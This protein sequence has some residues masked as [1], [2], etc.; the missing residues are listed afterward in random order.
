MEG[1]RK[2]VRLAAQT[3]IKFLEDEQD[4]A[5]SWDGDEPPAQ[6]P[7][8]RVHLHLPHAPA[9]SSL[10]KP[11]RRSVDAAEYD[12]PFIG[13]LPLEPGAALRMHLNLN[14]DVIPQ[15]PAATS[16]VSSR[17]VAASS[18]REAAMAQMTARSR[19]QRDAYFSNVDDAVAHMNA[20]L[21][22]AWRREEKR[23]KREKA[24]VAAERRRLS[25]SSG[26][27]GGAAGAG[28]GSSGGAGSDGDESS[29]G[30]GSESSGSWS[31]S[32]SSSASAPSS[33]SGRGTPE[34]DRLARSV[35]QASALL[36]EVH[37][38]KTDPCWL[39][40]PEHSCSE[41]T[42]DTEWGSAST[43]TSV[44]AD[45]AAYNSANEKKRRR[46]RWAQRDRKRRAKHRRRKA[47]KEA[48]IRDRERHVFGKMS[49][50]GSAYAVAAAA[51]A[52]AAGGAGEEA[53]QATA[54]RRASTASRLGLLGEPT[55]RTQRGP[56]FAASPFASL[57][58]PIA[59]PQ[60]QL[61][62][63]AA[64]PRV[65]RVLLQPAVFDF[66]DGLAPH[67][68]A[69]PRGGQLVTNFSLAKAVR[70]ALAE[71]RGRG[72]RGASS[73]GEE[74]EED[75][76]R[77]R[78]QRQLLR[79]TREVIRLL[80]EAGYVDE[81][82]AVAGGR[83]PPLH[84]FADG[85]SPPAM[86]AARE[87][88]RQEQEREHY[89]R[90]HRHSRHGSRHSSRRHRHHSRH[91]HSRRGHSHHSH[92]SKHGQHSADG[93]GQDS[94]AGLG[95]WGGSAG[96]QGFSP[97]DPTG[98]SPFALPHSRSPPR[99]PG[100]TG[101]PPPREE[102]D[103]SGSIKIASFQSYPAVA[104]A[105]AAAASQAAA[106]A[107][108]A[109]SAA[110][111]RGPSP[112]ELAAAAEETAQRLRAA[113]KGRALAENLTVLLPS[114]L[115]DES[116]EGGRKRRRRRRRRQQQRRRGSEGSSGG[117]PSP[118]AG[119]HGP[120][121]R[122]IRF[123]LSEAGPGASPSQ[124]YPP[125]P[126][127]VVSPSKRPLPASPAKRRSSALSPGPASAAV[128]PGAT[129]PGP[130]GLLPPVDSDAV[131]PVPSPLLDGDPFLVTSP[132]LRRPHPLY[133]SSP[134]FLS[135]QATF[136]S[137]PPVAPSPPPAPAPDSPS[138][139][140]PPLPASLPPLE[141][142]RWPRRRERAA[143]PRSEYA[144]GIP[145]EL[146]YTSHATGRDALQ[147]RVDGDGGVEAALA[148]LASRGAAAAAEALRAGSG[149]GPA[150]SAARSPLQDA[151][152]VAAI[153]RKAQAQY[154]PA[155]RPGPRPLGPP[156]AATASHA[157]LPAAV[158]DR[159]GRPAA[160][161]HS[162]SE[163]ALMA[164]APAAGQLPPVH[165]R[166]PKKPPREAAEAAA[167]AA[168]AVQRKERR[169][170]QRNLLRLLRAKG[171][172]LSPFEQL[173]A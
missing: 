155:A 22:A 140:P 10:K 7:A 130:R 163:P 82:A 5:R 86:R 60:L 88:A 25:G 118:W 9:H 28:A 64:R 101:Q 13:P 59:Q 45:P 93:R 11:K 125:S 61:Q 67:G 42:S 69:G 108:A 104:A 81:A 168:E 1:V 131:S 58:P 84:L 76:R 43:H 19:S 35:R 148:A 139:P 151:P 138:P 55:P 40:I 89:R 78:R 72:G 24:R 114:E 126:S 68:R 94:G 71:A 120:G 173:G 165:A 27:A 2:S 145:S 65:E 53:V 157:S 103:L 3:A 106:A 50:G 113:R 31:G 97:S 12:G 143:P 83:L 96:G 95:P 57:F 46:R 129:F 162:R 167:E 166:S 20:A 102:P 116:G 4:E 29:S 149:S 135:P 100:P 6:P 154:P 171:V 48:A 111:S 41:S 117:A 158:G 122:E 123:W 134:F 110:A 44:G 30:S 36:A 32:S 80:L 54:R 147:V 91:G 152:E 74:E 34:E 170:A 92:S 115:S 121:Q 79:V 107:A 26:H 70:E 141:P 75:E 161:A 128:S 66:G 142:E 85:H 14:W 132:L 16:G 47:R 73:D 112:T 52:A 8:P 137:P 98:A 172:A 17:T 160:L 39:P 21:E 18:R 105:Q 63:Q 99:S 146:F 144:K 169:A 23:R 136:S 164:A 33:A 109:A 127:K 38:A 56:S 15:A 51:A 124:T 37:R 150:A 159:E 153:L 156:G 119:Y 133:P 49:E 90:Q 87:R 62:P 77:R